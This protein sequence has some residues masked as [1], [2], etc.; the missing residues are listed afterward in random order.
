MARGVILF[1]VLLFAVPDIHAQNGGAPL[2][3]DGDTLVMV[4]GSRGPITPGQRARALSKVL[5]ELAK[6]DS[7]SIEDLRVTTRDSLIVIEIFGA[8]VMT[9]LPGD[10]IPGTGGLTATADSSLSAIRAGVRQYRASHE[11]GAWITLAIY[12]AVTFVVVVGLLWLIA[13]TF[14]RAY[15]ILRVL[16][17]KRFPSIRL[18]RV[19][20][21]SGAAIA[22]VL[23]LL[24]QVIRLIVTLNVIAYGVH[25]VLGRHPVTARYDVLPLTRS[26]VWALI[27]AVIAMMLYRVMKG[28][29]G[30]MLD[31]LA[32]RGEEHLKELGGQIA[33]MLP[34]T[35]TLKFLATAVRAGYVIG[36]AMLIY[37]ALTLVL[38]Q[39]NWSA[40]WYGELTAQLTRPLRTVALAILHYLPNLFFIVVI[41]VV[42]Y[43]TM[44][45]VRF[46]FTQIENGT[47]K[48]SGFDTDWAMPT[49]KLVRLLLLVFILIMLF[50]Y[51]PGSDSAAFKGVSIFLG[52]L[53]SLSSSSALSNIVAGSV[54]TYM[55]PFKIGD[56]VK[57]AD[58]MGDVV[59]KS[60]L[61]TRIR[62]PKKVEITI[63][64]AMVLGSHIINFS[65][66]ARE[67]GVILHTT[68]T[69]GY[70]VPWRKVYE[71]LLAAAS[72]VPELLDD[73]PPFVLQTSLGD[74]SVAYEINAY[75]RKPGEMAR[76]YGSLHE[77][78]QNRFAEAKVEILSPMY[79]AVRDGNPS[80]VPDPDLPPE[81]GQE[82][83]PSPLSWLG[84]RG[85][86]HGGG[87]TEGSGNE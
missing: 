44:Q 56:R 76:I 59:E 11:T 75:T 52:V 47:L 77:T 13:L 55:R 35:Q 10:T 51:L 87:D 49:Y 20:L 1:L 17:E 39:F 32:K 30:I 26:I 23:I 63:P 70:D 68:V 8:P 64:N 81:G 7:V 38:G 5:L 40:A 22:E 21:V 74:Y 80:T 6:S 71:L 50:P 28:L 66:G 29:R 69:I 9:L 73:P 78:I 45:I 24:L 85:T 57:I 82:P 14:P 15:R 3:L 16:G 67:Q 2:L 58:T 86:P 83:A 54:L 12:A 46:V 34:E 37:I 33:G 84:G 79:N 48:I 36:I 61:V 43:Y 62:T 18:K 27:I 25:F 72:D 19:T 53:F 4:Y 60:L 42:G 65:A 41:S 31:T